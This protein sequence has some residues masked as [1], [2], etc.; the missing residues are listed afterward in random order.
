MNVNIALNFGPVAY[1]FLAALALVLAFFVFVL[2][3]FGLAGLEAAA[4]AVHLVLQRSRQTTLRLETNVGRPEATQGVRREA[5][6]ELDRR[7]YTSIPPV[8]SLRENQEFLSEQIDIGT[9]S[10]HRDVPI[11]VPGDKPGVPTEQ[12]PDAAD[13]VAVVDIEPG[14]AEQLPQPLCDPPGVAQVH[15]G[16]DVEEGVADE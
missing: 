6:R 9:A 3:K 7:T 4:Q 11:E 8:D 16:L 15:D 10:K 13:A 5:D 12:Q 14:V 1:A 2:L